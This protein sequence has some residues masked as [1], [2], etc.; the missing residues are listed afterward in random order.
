MVRSVQ[1][2]GAILKDVK[3]EVGDTA[4]IIKLD[5]DKNPSAAQKYQVQGVLTL[6]LFKNGKPLWQQ[7][8]VVP[9]TVLAEVIKKFTA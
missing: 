1:N 6:I 9:R 7:S 8:G 3:K 4:K 5:V 2:D